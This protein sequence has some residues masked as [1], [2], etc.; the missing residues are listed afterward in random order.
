M[1]SEVIEL[2]DVISKV[3][4][5]GF[6]IN[7]EIKSEVFA[8]KK[9]IRASEFYD[10]RKV[11]YALDIM[12]EVKPYDFNEQ[13]FILYEGKKYKIERMYQKNSE[14]LELVCRKED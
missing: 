11:G 9:S 3:D 4:E 2:I 7:E 14:I 13:E 12:F 8:N 10:A 1:F 5:E 6:E